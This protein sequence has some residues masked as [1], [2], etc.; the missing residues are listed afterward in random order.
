MRIYSSTAQIVDIPTG[1]N[2]AWKNLKQVEDCFGNDPLEQLLRSQGRLL[3]RI[4]HLKEKMMFLEQCLNQQ[5]QE[6][7]L[8]HF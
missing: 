4:D 8:S 1:F 3:Q 7:T 5:P 6:T 2:R